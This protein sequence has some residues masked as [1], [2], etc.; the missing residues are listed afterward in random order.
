M[1]NFIK[2]LFWITIA[3][4]VA[5]IMLSKLFLEYKHFFASPSIALFINFSES[6]TSDN[7]YSVVYFFSPGLQWL[8]QEVSYSWHPVAWGQMSPPMDRKGSRTCQGQ[9][10]SH[11]SQL[12]SCRCFPTKQWIHKQV[13]DLAYKMWNKTRIVVETCLNYHWLCLCCSPNIPAY[14]KFLSKYIFSYQKL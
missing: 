9:M 14:Q 5:C 7:M 3:T 13:Q 12:S 11:T 10:L 6:G 4:H 1:N 2:W 8:Q